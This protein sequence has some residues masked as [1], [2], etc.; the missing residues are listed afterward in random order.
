MN[1]T[2]PLPSVLTH[3]GGSR[4][5]ISSSIESHSDTLDV[6]HRTVM[7]SSRTDE[8]P[9]RHLHYGETFSGESID[10]TDYP[11]HL[12]KL[13]ETIPVEPI[14]MVVQTKDEETAAIEAGWSITPAE[15]TK[16]GHVMITPSEQI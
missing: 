5:A 7:D 8:A 6:Q 12:H 10:E 4:D 11:K 3:G 16:D 15:K 2:N 9:F 13:S 1:M 14:Y